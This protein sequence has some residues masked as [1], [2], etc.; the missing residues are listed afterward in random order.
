MDCENIKSQNPVNFQIFYYEFHSNTVQIH[1]EDILCSYLCTR[2]CTWLEYFV[3]HIF[4]FPERTD[5]VENKVCFTET[6]RPL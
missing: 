1:F 5:A 4:W 6:K 3:I 2:V